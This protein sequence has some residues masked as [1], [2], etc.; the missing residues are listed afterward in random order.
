MKRTFAAFLLALAASF[1]A[2]PGYA[3][4]SGATPLSQIL[5]EDIPAQR[6]ALAAKLVDL[7]GTARLFDQLL[8]N[9]ADQAKNS[10]IRAN[11]QMQL[12][13][14]SVVD[15]I[16]VQLVSRRPELDNYLARVWA[17]GFTDEELQGLVDFYSSDLGSKYA[18]ALP[19]LLAVQTAAAEEWAK[20]VNVEL[21]Q[22][23]QE[24]LRAAMAAETQALQNDVAGPA[25]A[26][27]Q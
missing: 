10:F 12:G 2:A 24:E 17:S 5:S 22:K 21:T 1:L 23:V 8:P 9:I 26:P 4:D 6:L 27:Q 14:I 3:Q 18:V 15:K 25:Q 7:T 13:I 19:Q 11:P 20:S 16:A